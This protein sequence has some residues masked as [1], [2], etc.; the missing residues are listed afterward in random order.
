MAAPDKSRTNLAAVAAAHPSEGEVM[1]TFSRKFAGVLGMLS[2]VVAGCGGGDGDAPAAAG[3]GEPVAAVQIENP[4]SITGSV[5]FTGTAPAAEA[6]DMRDEPV[7]SEK[8]STPPVRQAVQVNSNG[9][10]ANVFIWVREGLTQTFPA[11]SEAVQLD[12]NG[13]VYVPHVMGVQAG[14]PISILNSDAV[15]H[16]VN[17]QPTINRGFNISQPQAGMT[18]E[19][20]F[21]EPEVMI[22]VQCD[23]HGWMQAYIGVV[24][25]PYFAVTSADGSYR[26]E[27]LPPGDYVIEAWHEQYGTQTL[28]VTVPPNG[29]VEAPFS[30]DAS[31]AETAVVP[32]G[33]PIDLHGHHHPS[34]GEAGGV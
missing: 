7:C 16:N 8:H 13:C 18:S 24:N 19:R 34:T 20:T 2:F 15:L 17:T 11:P 27:N 29:T 10:L 21:T 12:Q 26:I 33:D 23:V 25:H 5:A 6:I 31:M 28:N 1:L 32:L 14:Q 3:G 30:Y 4:G 22:P 9:T